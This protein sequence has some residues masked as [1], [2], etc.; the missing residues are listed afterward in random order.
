MLTSSTTDVGDIVSSTVAAEVS[1]REDNTMEAQ[2]ETEDADDGSP[3]LAGLS[4]DYGEHAQ[5]HELIHFVGAITDRGPRQSDAECD[6]QQGRAATS[7]DGGSGSG[8]DDVVR[9]GGSDDDSDDE[10]AGDL[11]AVPEIP[12]VPEYGGD[13]TPDSDK[14][15]VVGDKYPFGMSMVF[16]KLADV[17]FGWKA[18]KES[19]RDSI[20]MYA[21][22][23]MALVSVLYCFLIV[24]ESGHLP[25][26]T[27][28]FLSIL[29]VPPAVLALTTLC[30]LRRK[31]RP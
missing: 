28:Q 19:M 3:N 18:P 1:D 9:T 15:P 20:D 22:L 8:G 2:Q 23:G 25:H 5:Q 27:A 4:G 17:H 14:D 7:S 26:G 21:L 6:A 10:S 24:I 12:D 11:P 30:F 16:G 29:F 13:P 31:N